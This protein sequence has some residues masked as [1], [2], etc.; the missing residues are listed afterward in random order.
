MAWINDLIGAGGGV[1]AVSGTFGYPQWGVARLFSTQNAAGGTLELSLSGQASINNSMTR[2]WDMTW[3]L[4]FNANTAMQVYFG[5]GDGT[6]ALQ[7]NGV[8][9][10]FDT[11]LGDTAWFIY[12]MNTSVQTAVTTGVPVD[13]TTTFHNFRM[14]GDGLGTVTFYID[15]VVVGTRSTGGPAGTTFLRPAGQLLSVGVVTRHFNIDFFS[16]QERLTR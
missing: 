8:G 12:T 4:N 5:L 13:A 14:V 7:T 16:Y 11:T 15:G 10:R 3:I 9:F 1:S 6:T 2:A